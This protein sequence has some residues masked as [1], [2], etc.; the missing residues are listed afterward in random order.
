MATNTAFPALDG[1]ATIPA[2]VAR[3]EGAAKAA[4]IVIPEIFGV[5]PGIRQKC[6]SWARDGY[7]AIAPDI[8]WRFAPGIELDPDVP[9]QL[10]EAFGYFGQ[11]DP[12][13]G[14]QD[15]EAAIRHIRGTEGV[16]KVGLVGYCLGGRM[17]YMAAA[18][19]DIDASVGY[20]GVMIDQ[21]LGEAH[22]IANPLMLHIPTAD[23]FVG[24]EAQAAIHAG[25]DSH[26]K[27]TLHDYEGLDHGFAAEMGDRR[28]EA[29]AQ[30]AD[31]RTRAFLAAN[32]A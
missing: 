17:A 28:D 16:G 32:L 27:V 29:G 15:I 11:Y 31:S 22:A 19:T 21:M 6:D 18:R 25:L 5:N 10:Q 24:P 9:D 7:L 8:F 13:L 2:Y 12:D 20:Y 26:P 1:S 3:P 14:V 30:L 23:H 4:I